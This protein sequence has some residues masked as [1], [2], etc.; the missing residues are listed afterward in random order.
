MLGLF[1]DTPVVGKASVFIQNPSD[2]LFNFIGTDLL[3]NYPR[4]SP[5]VRELEKLTEGPVKQGTLCRQVRIDQGNRSESTFKVQIFE[6]GSRICFEGISNPY[7]CD[8]IIEAV[9]PTDSRITFVF[10]LLTIELHMRPFEKLIRIAVQDGTERTVRN[11]KKLIESA[12]SES[13]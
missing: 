7:R 3:L 9:N 4:W 2:K 5:E 1:K 12:S 13:V 8:Y 6:A 10:E 11:I